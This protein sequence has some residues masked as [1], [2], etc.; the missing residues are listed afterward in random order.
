MVNRFYPEFDGEMKVDNKYGDWIKYDD[1][2]KE[3]EE[4]LEA[5]QWY[6][7]NDDVIESDDYSP[8]GGLTWNEVNEY[9]INGKQKAI[10]LINKH[11]EIN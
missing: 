9:W 4:L 2:K 5:L 6:V 10:N 8:R 1:H 7:D 3:I 11:K